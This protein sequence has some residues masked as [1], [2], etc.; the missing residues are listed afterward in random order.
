MVNYVEEGRRSA[1]VYAPECLEA[2]D[3]YT[4]FFGGNH[5]LVKLE[6][7]SDSDRVLLVLKDSYANCFVP[8][9]IPDYKA[10]VMVDPRYYTGDLETLMSAE[11]VTEVLFMYNA[12]TFSSDTAL[13]GD[14]A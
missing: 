6:M 7:L 8:F 9:L 1:T 4:V 10:I 11:G 2:R 13:K 5:A 14:I 12:N 3:K